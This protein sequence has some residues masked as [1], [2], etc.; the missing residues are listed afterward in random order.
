MHLAITIGR[1]KARACQDYWERIKTASIPDPVA[2]ELEDVAPEKLAWQQRGVFALVR[3]IRF[4]IAAAEDVAQCNG[5]C[6][7]AVLVCSE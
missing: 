7:C 3:Q 1:E 6:G 2:E 4:G 5:S